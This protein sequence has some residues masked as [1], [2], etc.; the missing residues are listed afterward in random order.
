MPPSRRVV[1]LSCCIVV[2]LN[3]IMKLVSCPHTTICSLLSIHP[4]LMRLAQEL[5]HIHIVHLTQTQTLL[6]LL[7]MI[8]I[9]DVHYFKLIRLLIS[10]LSSQ[11]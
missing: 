7:Y 6:F 9:A 4:N 5:L 10:H 11:C 2:D 1:I 3:D 8:Y